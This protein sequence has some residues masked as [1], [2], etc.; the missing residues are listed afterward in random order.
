MAVDRRRFLVLGASLAG[1]LLTLQLGGCAGGPHG[2]LAVRVAQL[3][4]PE[5][6]RI[7]R[8][9]REQASP[10]RTELVDRLFG[11]PEWSDLAPDADP[12]DVTARLAAQVAA[13]HRAG[14]VVVVR[15]WRLAPTEVALS[16]LAAL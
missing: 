5:A 2:R 6:D 7:G 10:T 13:E 8:A 16:A 14:E 4:P 3:L 15:R 12:E 1:G 11:R 9:W